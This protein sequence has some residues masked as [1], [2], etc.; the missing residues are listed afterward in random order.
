MAIRRRPAEDATLNLTPMIDVVFLLVIFFM[1]GARFSQNQG[2]IDVEVP[3]VGEVQP[4]VRGP[5]G[6]TVQLAPDGTLTLDGVVV[7]MEQLRAELQA[8]HTAYP[9][10]RVTVRADASESLEKFTQVLQ[11]CRSSGVENLGIAVKPRAPNGRLR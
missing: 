4:L 1:V 3:G 10:L 7:S 6:R 5:D 9:A 8:A 2:R 11:L